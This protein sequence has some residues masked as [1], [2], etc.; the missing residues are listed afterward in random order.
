[1]TQPVDIAQSLSSASITIDYFLDSEL[2]QSGY[3]ITLT[4][5]CIPGSIHYMWNIVGSHFLFPG[6]MC[7]VI[8]EWWHLFFQASSFGLSLCFSVFSCFLLGNKRKQ[9]KSMIIT[10]QCT[11]HFHIQ[12]QR[13]LYSKKVWQDCPWWYFLWPPCLGLEHREKTSSWQALWQ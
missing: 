2:L 9:T 13:G 1:M 5:L 3:S 8:H 10:V 7:A 12:G 4:D 6:R 11:N